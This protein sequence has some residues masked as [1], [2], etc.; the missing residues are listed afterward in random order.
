MRR[1]RL[2]GATLND[3]VLSLVAGAL[4]RWLERPSTARSATCGSASP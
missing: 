1:S 4:R 2:D 3:A